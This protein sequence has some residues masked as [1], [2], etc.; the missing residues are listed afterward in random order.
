MR[1]AYVL[2]LFLVA[3]LAAPALAASK[4]A[5]KLVTASG[6]SG[7]FAY[8][9]YEFSSGLNPKLGASGTVTIDVLVASATEKPLLRDGTLRSAK[10]HV[11]A[12]LPKKINKTYTFGGAK[13][14]SVSF[15]TGH[16]GPAAVV[17]L[18]YAKLTA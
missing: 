8:T 12:T 7:S 4:P 2:G 9:G 5:F 3:L 15:V 14:T 16:F 18:S 10:L 11:L 6:K 1:R 17:V 13:I